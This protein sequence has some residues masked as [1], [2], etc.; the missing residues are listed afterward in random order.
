MLDVSVLGFS[1]VE[2]VLVLQG[3]HSPDLCSIQCTK[4]CKILILQLEGLRTNMVR[5]PDQ[6][7]TGC[8]QNAFIFIFNAHRDRFIVAK[9]ARDIVT[10][11]LRLVLFILV[12]LVLPEQKNLY[13]HDR[14]K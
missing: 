2:H 10:S 8:G 11:F 7:R 4:R 14:Y 6:N 13:T 9:A 12:V 1:V 5:S 3:I